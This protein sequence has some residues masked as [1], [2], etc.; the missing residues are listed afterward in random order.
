MIT[1]KSGISRSIYSA[2]LNFEIFFY[3]PMLVPCRMYIISVLPSLQYLDDSVITDLHRLQ[4]NS[5]KRAYALSGGP[6][7]FIEKF[8]S[9]MFLNMFRNGGSKANSKQ[10]L[11]KPEATDNELAQLA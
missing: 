5:N 8:G 11:V 2:G 1:G 6:L 4:A 10:S 9:T 7:R 3:V